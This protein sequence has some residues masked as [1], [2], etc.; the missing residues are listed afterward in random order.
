MKIHISRR[1]AAA[2]IIVLI[3]ALITGLGADLLIRNLGQLILALG[4][5]LGM[6]KSTADYA[7]ILNQLK[8]ARMD[9]PSLLNLLLCLPIGIGILRMGAGKRGVVISSKQRALRIGGSVLLC[10]LLLPLVVVITL[11]FTDV[12][13]IRF[14]TAVSF[15]YDAIKNGIF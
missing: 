12:N 8:S 5:T 15:L 9:L 7:A 11:W 3:L 4:D 6:G 13:D 1:V 2:L 10:L 14:G